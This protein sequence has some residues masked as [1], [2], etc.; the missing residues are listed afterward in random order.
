MH[1][2]FRVDCS[3]KIGSGHLMRCLN[4]GKR[5][6]KK[7]NKIYF[8]VKKSDY[9]KINNKLILQ[10]KFLPVFIGKEENEFSRNSDVN[11]TLK[12]CR[13]KKIDTIIV[14]NYK[15]DYKWEKKI[16]KK[17]NKLIVIDD[18]ANRKH[19]CDILIDH[20]YVKNFSLRYNNLVNKDCIKLLGPK[21]CLLDDSFKN[22]NQFFS[23][24]A[25][26]IFIFFSTVFKPRLFNLIT[27]V[28]SRKEF[29]NLKIDYVVGNLDKKKISKF[30][31]TLPKNFNLLTKK[32]NLYNTMKKSS[33]A[34]G[35]GS[36]NTWERINMALPSIVFC[37]APNQ[38]RICNFLNEKKIIKYLG[39]DKNYSK[40][41][42]YSAIRFMINNFKKQKTIAIENK[43]LIDGNG[44]RRINFFISKNEINKFTLKKI[45]NSDADLLFMWIN[46]PKV[47]QNSFLVK[48]ISY[49][50]HKIW[51]K[52]KLLKKK[53]IFLKLIVNGVPV[54]QIRF[55]NK[56]KF[57]YVDY[58]IDDAFR[59]LGFGKLI[60]KE[61][62]KK[63]IKKN[64]KVRADVKKTNLNSIK[65][66]QSLNFDEIKNNFDNRSF[67]LNT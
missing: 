67:V 49:Q 21:Y 45:K 17:I 25:K 40:R 19:F 35:S 63:Y 12:I 34:I 3:S 32:K 10:N 11:A 20:N 58:S 6:K 39:S 14:D 44:A 24:N 8:L 27:H 16:K 43:H 47:R 60:I 50:K 23:N 57:Y 62:I 13:K 64:K 48:K 28:L 59:N 56:K 5:I 36:T 29:K 66:F 54:G 52:K 42:F 46:D 33:F 37:I 9:L 15:I 7:N 22:K 26:R 30:K 31:K 18:L 1:I 55:D 61:S 51:L 4:L 38:K 41:K 65:I 53:S 2:A